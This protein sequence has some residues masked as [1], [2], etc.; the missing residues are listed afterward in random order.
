MENKETDLSSQ[1]FDSVTETDLLNLVTDDINEELSNGITDDDLAELGIE[2]DETDGDS[3]ET[4]SSREQEEEEELL[5]ED[6]GDED[7]EE[8]EEPTRF[9]TLKGDDG[10]EFQVPESAVVKLMVDNQEVDVGL[11]EL[12]KNYS[13]KVAW[14]KRFNELNKQKQEFE[15]KS[16]KPIESFVNE[17]VQASEKG[18]YAAIAVI[19]KFA[20]KDPIEFTNGFKAAA[21]AEALKYLNMDEK[22]QALVDKEDELNLRQIQQE[23]QVR[24]E[25]SQREVLKLQEQI[26]EQM[27]E[28]GISIDEFQD[29]VETL[30]NYLP[31]DKHNEI[32]PEK[33][34]R[35]IKLNRRADVVEGVLNEIN[36][37]L[38]SDDKLV[39]FL[40]TRSVDDGLDDQT[41]IENIRSYYGKPKV[42]PSVKK[43]NA[44]LSK[45]GKK[46]PVSKQP[47]ASEMGVKGNLDS[48]TF[49][50][51][52]DLF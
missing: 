32:T 11:E 1:T 52:D 14:D 7:E 42:D 50:D 31:E 23:L 9:V 46:R 51:L 47:T 12:K 35:W 15:N 28:L 13:G 27:E 18:P 30:K 25:Q 19:A 37:E 22:S 29:S 49:A 40:V 4:D 2:V 43:V 34:G 10:S 8:E 38:A 33:V 44:K 36:A 26:T 45:A 24:Q 16:K 6:E 48:M 20:G 5:E 21:R 17:F 3:E 41:T 39:A